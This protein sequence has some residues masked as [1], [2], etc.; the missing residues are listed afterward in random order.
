MRTIMFAAML[1]LTP[2]AAL[3]QSSPIGRGPLDTSA[4]GAVHSCVDTSARSAVV[5]GPYSTESPLS[6]R[7]CAESHR[8]AGRGVAA[9]L[10][11]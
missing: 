8:G 1:A 5:T 6:V 11:V 4:D 3:A 7:N 9:T 2:A 10:D